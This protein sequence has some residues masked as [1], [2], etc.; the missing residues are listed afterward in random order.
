MISEDGQSFWDHRQP[1]HMHVV[2]SDDKLLFT[3][4]FSAKVPSGDARFIPQLPGSPS[5]SDGK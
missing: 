3:L 1:F 2:D 5:L 4:E